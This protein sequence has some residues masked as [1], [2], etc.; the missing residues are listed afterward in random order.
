M[1]LEM[2]DLMQGQGQAPPVAVALPS[3]VR[4]G[5]VRCGTLMCGTLMR[6]ALM[7]GTLIY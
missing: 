5:M 3:Q 1:V 6:G 7:R 2:L 4:R